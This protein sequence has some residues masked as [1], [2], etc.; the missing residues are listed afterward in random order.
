MAFR[1]QPFSGLMLLRLVEVAMTSAW[2][3]LYT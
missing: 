1:L 2:R 3:E